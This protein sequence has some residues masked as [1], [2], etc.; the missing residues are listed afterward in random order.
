MEN[1]KKRKIMQYTAISAILIILLMLGTFFDLQIS[2]K[3]ASLPKGFYH[4][5]NIFGRI[6]ETIGEMPIYVITSVAAV[7]LYQNA[8]RRKKTLLNITLKILCVA[9]SLALS[10]YMF[11][12]LFKYI[13]QHFSFEDKIGSFFDYLAYFLLGVI[14]TLSLIFLTKKI[15][16]NF[17]NKIFKI[18]LIVLFTALF[19]QILSNILKIFAGRYRYCTMNT[20]G[21]FSLFSPWYVFNG[22]R[23]PTEEM[24]IL[25]VASDGLK[26]FPSGHTAAASMV[27][28]FTALP[29]FF[30]KINNKRSKIIINVTC[31]LYIVLVMFSRII[32]GK[33]FLSD[34]VIGLAITLL[35]YLGATCLVKFFLN[36][37]KISSLNEL[38]GTITEEVL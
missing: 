25:G 10:Y 7:L 9:I 35:S 3:I 34:V 26:S 8:D 14:Y 6:F 27:I 38:K 29:T 1:I 23:Q 18:C 37:H 30:E 19:S 17:L 16:N 28:V 32:M 22:K 4:S 24:K 15:Q 33:H 5:P 13:S 20:I 2:Q 36:K 31:W 11:Y 12:K 21:D